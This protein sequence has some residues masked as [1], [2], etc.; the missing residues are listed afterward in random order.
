MLDELISRYGYLA[1]LLGTFLEGETI[2]VLGGLAAHKGLLS[3][4]GV[5]ACGFLGSLASDQLFFFIGRRRGAAFVARRPRLQA[6]LGRVRG[7]VER[8]A[9]LLALSF[10]FLYGLRNV[11]P[12]ALGMSR[13]PALRFALLNAVGAAA[14]AIAVAALGWWVGRAARQVI[15]HLEHY[16]LRAAAAIIAI[17]L[18]LWAWRRWVRDAPGKG[19]G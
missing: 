17:G 14:W 6:G 5:M 8:H 13:V 16:E 4:P 15:G 3:L 12:L 18:G 9:T 11:T 2:L 7:V 1:I 19:T 10:R